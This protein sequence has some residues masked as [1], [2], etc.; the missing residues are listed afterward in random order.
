MAPKLVWKIPSFFLSFFR[1]GKGEGGRKNDENILANWNS[2]PEP[3]FLCVILFKRISGFK[4][5]KFRILKAF[6]NVTFCQSVNRSRRFE[7]SSCC[8]VQGRTVR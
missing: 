4:S 6:W 3:R 5:P 1:K 8:H 7:K 2:S